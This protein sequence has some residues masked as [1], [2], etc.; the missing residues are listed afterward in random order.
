LIVLDASAAIE[1]VLATPT[2]HRVA[3]R[4]GSGYPRPHAPHLL[5]VEVAHVLR[6]FAARGQISPAEGNEG[7][8][9]LTQLN[10]HRWEHE[11]LLRRVWELRD[12]LTA[13]DAVY[14]ALAEALEAPLLT[15]DARL[16]R[17]TGHSA[18]VELVTS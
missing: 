12:N 1:L 13:Y 16:V 3:A 14:V 11:P 18:Q 15:T 4:L 5:A 17:A 9:A 8:E 10:V 6:R 2:G 7:L